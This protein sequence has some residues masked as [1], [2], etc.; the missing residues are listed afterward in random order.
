MSELQ[1]AENDSVDQDQ[2]L[3]GT[4][5]SGSDLATDSGENR[6]ENNQSLA[7][8]D[9]VN[10]AIN[11]Q[12]AKYRE[13]ERKRLDVE[14]KNKELQ[15]KLAAYEAPKEPVVLPIPDQYSENYVEEFKAYK[16]SVSAKAR[17]DA[18]Q[19]FKAKQQNEQQVA[20]QQEEQKQ[21]QQQVDQY[22]AKASEIGLNVDEVVKAGETLVSYGVSNDVAMF[23]LGD[24]D[25]PL[26]TTHLAANPVEVSELMAMNPMQA[27]IYLNNTVREKA[28]SL[29]PQ[30]SNAPDPAIALSGN[31]P[32]EKVPA[33]IKGARFE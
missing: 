26:M 11:K 29:R 21:V 32:G 18:E 6:E 3:T 28:G 1:T 19:D 22:R 2:D 4:V 15:E 17:F 8:Q 25:G 27:A 24:P 16:E 33:S 5:E 9:T 13:E 7:N 10:A 20:K 31:G 14:Q 23:L 30:T 12:H